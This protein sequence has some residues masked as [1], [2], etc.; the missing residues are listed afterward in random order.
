MSAAQEIEQVNKISDIA[1]ASRFIYSGVGDRAF[2]AVKGYQ[3]PDSS[4]AVTVT[5]AHGSKFGDA[6]LS[7]LR[8]ALVGGLRLPTEGLNLGLAL[9]SSGGLVGFT[10]R[11]DPKSGIFV[12]QRMIYKGDIPDDSNLRPGTHNVA[13][14]LDPSGQEAWAEAGAFEKPNAK[15]GSQ[16]KEDR[17]DVVMVGTG[18]LRQLGLP[19]IPDLYATVLQWVSMEVRDPDGG[20]R[21]LSPEELAVRPILLSQ[22][23]G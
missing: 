8:T 9:D 21:H 6:R 17:P 11:P 18:Y 23:R 12:S 10:G 14:K 20:Y 22:T 16:K 13:Y 1:L 4:V 19:E 2:I 5:L 15:H 7:V 3:V